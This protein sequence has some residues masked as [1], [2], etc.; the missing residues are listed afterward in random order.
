MQNSWI[1]EET[2]R[3]NALTVKCKKCNWK[4]NDSVKMLGHMTSHE[5][6][7]CNKCDKTERTQADLNHHIQTEHRPDLH[8]C[9]ACK[10]Q[11]QAQNA[12][13]Q[14]MNSQH[15]ANPPVG[16][17]QWADDRNKVQDLDYCCNQCGNCF[18]EQK[19]LR[20]HKK[21]DHM[22]QT[23]QGFTTVKAQCHF[24]L[25]GRCNRNPCKFSHNQQ[26]QQH[27]N[28]Q[29]Q[30]HI[31]PQQQNHQQQQSP[32]CSR[33]QK[34]C[35]L[36]WGTCNFFHPG[37]GVQQPRKMSPQNNMNRPN[38]KCHFQENCWNTDCAFDHE[39]F[40]LRKEFLENY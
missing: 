3:H 12:L 33:G 20:E 25:Q 35:F 4:T 36:A 40:S 27:I 23:F 11:F 39:D 16:H 10:K 2:R 24:Y 1:S 14:H 21:K 37:V 38:K 31:Q 29:H 9:N 13:K 22:G 15:P 19:Q 26:Q 5:G 28:Q 32:A 7:K 34:C 18:A 30:Q 6:Y 17:A 8:T